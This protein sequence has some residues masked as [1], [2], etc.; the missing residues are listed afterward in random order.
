MFQ[1]TGDSVD[2]N[3]DLPSHLK[4]KNGQWNSSSF[5][6]CITCI[7]TKTFAEL[8]VS[9]FEFSGEDENGCVFGY[10]LI[11]LANQ[12]FF[13]PNVFSPN[14]EQINDYFNLI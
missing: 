4:F 12:G 10:K 11:I 1:I 6:S 3:V 7:K 13:V 8:G 2:L 5:I 9:I 14:G